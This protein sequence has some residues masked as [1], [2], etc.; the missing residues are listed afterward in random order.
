[1]E[2][3]FTEAPKLTRAFLE[4]KLTRTEQ[5]ESS[6]KVRP[7]GVK[8]VRIFATYFI[9]IFSPVLRTRNTLVSSAHP[10]SDTVS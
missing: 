1:M 6:W 10:S 7:S 9:L 8:V 5:D 2:H 4:K 3:N